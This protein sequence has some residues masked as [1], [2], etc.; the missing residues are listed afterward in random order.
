MNSA[1]GGGESFEV[2]EAGGVSNPEEDPT[3]TVEEV[4]E[5]SE[6]MTCSQSSAVSIKI[7]ILVS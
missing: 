7:V 1:K 3:S 6:V 2:G 4:T 5:K